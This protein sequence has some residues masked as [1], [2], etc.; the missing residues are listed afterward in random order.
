[1]NATDKK[2]SDNQVRFLEAYEQHGSILKAGKATNISRETVRLWRRADKFGFA[3]RFND[4]AATFF[5][6]VESVFFERVKQSDCDPRLVALFLRSHAPDKYGEVKVVADTT[7]QDTLR[8]LRDTAKREQERK[9]HSPEPEV[10]AATAE[11]RFLAT[12][13]KPA[14]G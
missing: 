2:T 1:M 5:E 10:D 14:A 6:E 13:P 7:A 3:E 8:F 9:Q 4:S 11:A 12:L